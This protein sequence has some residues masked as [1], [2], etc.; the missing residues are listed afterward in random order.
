ML[1]VDCHV[2]KLTL[3]GREKN[4]SFLGRVFPVKHLTMALKKLTYSTQD[5][6]KKPKDKRKIRIAKK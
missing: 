1:I 5:K 6:H 2:T 3:T 4:R